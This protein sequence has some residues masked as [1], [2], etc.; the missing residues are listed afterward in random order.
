MNRFI[1]VTL[2]AAALG[3]ASHPSFSGGSQDEIIAIAK[4]ELARRHIH[5]P[6][7]CSVKVVEGVT[8]F[9]VQKAQ[10]EYFVLFTFTLRG[11]R[12]AVFKVVVGRQSKRVVEFVD[13]R[14]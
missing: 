4:A 3:C 12:D 8:V 1:I 6:R 10:K 14:E 7:D 5:L 9:P 2:C 13:Y 11:K